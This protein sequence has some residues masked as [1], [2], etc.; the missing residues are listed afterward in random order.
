MRERMAK[1]DNK[2]PVLDPYRTFYN[3]WRV[4]MTIVIVFFLFEIPLL[5]GFTEDCTLRSIAVYL[6]IIVSQGY[7][8]VFVLASV[9]LFLD[10]IINLN[11][12]YYQ[13]GL[14]VG[15]RWEIFSM[16]A[17][18]DLYVDLFCVII[19]QLTYFYYSLALNI[20]KLLFIL[21]VRQLAKYDEQYLYLLSTYRL[22]KACYKF[23]RLVAILLFYSHILACIFF[24]I[25]YT[26]YLENYNGY[27]DKGYLWLL[28][29]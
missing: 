2:I 24:L 15:Q 14:F 9:L 8:L 6:F 11:L 20:I 17:R 1:F 18:F 25:D 5:L 21:K 7:F 4:A 26:F 28:T 13:K 23:F 27:V 22:G 19:V 3:C 10:I 29:A 12:G 16:Y